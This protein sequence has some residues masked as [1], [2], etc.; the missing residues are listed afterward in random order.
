MYDALPF[1]GLTRTITSS[2]IVHFRLRFQISLDA[3]EVV[4]ATRIHTS[5]EVISTTRGIKHYPGS[6]RAGSGESVGS[7][8]RQANQPIMLENNA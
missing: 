4:H 3:K 2:S 5:A 7:M 6:Y 8:D 1:S